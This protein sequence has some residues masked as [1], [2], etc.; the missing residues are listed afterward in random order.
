MR[1]VVD[2]P[3][4]LGPRKP[5]TVPGWTVKSRSWTTV[6]SPYRLVSPYAL[7]MRPT[8]RSGPGGGRP[9]GG[10]TWAGA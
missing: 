2:F 4:P 6:L 7:I 10:G 5:V 1:I 3:A 9:T 8:L